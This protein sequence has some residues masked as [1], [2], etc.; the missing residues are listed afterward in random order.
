MEKTLNG[1]D[2]SRWTI[3]FVVVLATFMATL[4]SS[5]VNVALP[6]M[7]DS[8]HVTTASISWV[9]SAYLIAISA[10]ILVFGKLGDIFGQTKVFQFGLIIFTI[11]SFLCGV[12]YSFGWLILAR[13]VQAIGAAGTMANS[14]GIITRTFPEN[15]RGRALGINGAF[16][17]LGSLVGPA[18]GGFIISVAS[19]EYLFWI[20]VPIGIVVFLLGAKVYPKNERQEKV[21][22]D[23]P[24]AMLF[25]VAI[26]PLFIALEQSVTLGFGYITVIACLAVSA[27][28]FILFYQVERRGKT[29][30]LPMDVF[31]NKW[32]TVSLFC[33]FISFIAISFS[34]II[35]PFYLQDLLK[36]SPA[37]SGL[38]LSIFPLVLGITAPISGYLSDRIGSEFLTLLGLIL[39]ALGLFLVSTLDKNPS[40]VL[41]GVFI[42]MIGGGNGLFQ[43]PNN[44]L[45]MSS[46]PK[47][48]LGIGGSL[49]ALVRNIGLVAGITFAT[50]ILYGG[51][52]SRIGYTVNDYFEGADDAFL[53]GMRIAFITAGLVCT[54]GAVVTAA[55]LSSVKKLKAGSGRG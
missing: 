14:Q 48:D 16:V 28:G 43:S 53:Y 47:K 33:A 36:M 35:M 3:L 39:T 32:F 12:T 30:L 18:L 44:S 42:A 50:M 5:I 9:V 55:R 54:L 8:M 46:L 40:Y 10:A 45:V 38:F 25:V 52:S 26:V 19:W 23:V 4:D 29:P 6:V 27:V 15:E 11:G 1:A 34:N 7:T 51:M 13:V 49:N 20:N 24:G 17:A 2:R 22:I 31:K 41:M 37:F 21:K